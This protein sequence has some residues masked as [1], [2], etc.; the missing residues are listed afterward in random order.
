MIPVNQYTCLKFGGERDEDGNIVGKNYVKNYYYFTKDNTPDPLTPNQEKYLSC[1]NS[2]KPDNEN[3]PRYELVSNYFPLWD[4]SDLRF[5]RLREVNMLDIN[6]K[7]RER[8]F[9]EY[10]IDSPIDLFNMIFTPNSPTKE[11]SFKSKDYYNL[12]YMMI[13]FIDPQS[14]YST[15]PAGE[16][17]DP[18][19]LILREY[20][21]DTE[22]LYHSEKEMEIVKKGDWEQHINGNHYITESKLVKYGFYVQNGE[23][24]KLHNAHPMHTKTI[25]YHYPFSEFLDP[26]EKGDR[27]LFTIIQSGAT[28][29]TTDNRIGCVPKIED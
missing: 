22:A 28:R 26:L 5:K 29:Y 25:F 2:S 1:T 10:G 6:Y 3:L 13:P 8:L 16:S 7:I 17:Y 12:G 11:T 19:L 23:K 15:C 4:K 20:I 24:I 14:G 9:N 21:G 18:L 27:K